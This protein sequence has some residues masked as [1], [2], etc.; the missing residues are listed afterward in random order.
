MARF[1]LEYKSGQSWHDCNPVLKNKLN[2][3]FHAW[4]KGQHDGVNYLR[5]VCKQPEKNLFHIL[6]NLK[7]KI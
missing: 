3:V 4:K 7:K 5:D 2:L 6:T 1:I